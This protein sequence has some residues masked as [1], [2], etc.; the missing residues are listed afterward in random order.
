MRNATFEHNDNENSEALASLLEIHG[1]RERLTEA[2]TMVLTALAAG[3]SVCAS[4][5]S[6]VAT[7]ES[8]SLGNGTRLSNI[9]VESLFVRELVEEAGAPALEPKPSLNYPEFWHKEMRFLRLTERG[10]NEVIRQQLHFDPRVVIILLLYRVNRLQQEIECY[11]SAYGCEP[12]VALRGTVPAE[13]AGWSL[14]CSTWRKGLASHDDKNLLGLASGERGDDEQ[15]L[16][17]VYP[18]LH[19]FSL[20]SPIRVR[21]R[22]AP[23]S[24]EAQTAEHQLPPGKEPAL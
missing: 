10:R 2:Q 12:E 1:P 16:L 24:G 4:R 14:R 5:S 17:W 22:P 19:R 13:Q 11:R 15:H 21:F 7:R 8:V 23:F 18:D 3:Y 20:T 9:T 6:G